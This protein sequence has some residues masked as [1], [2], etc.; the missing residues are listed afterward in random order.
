MKKLLSILACGLLIAAC[1]GG[2]GSGSTS[3]SSVIQPESPFRSAQA[4]TTPSTNA[5]MQ[6]ITIGVQWPTGQ[7]NFANTCRTPNSGGVACF[8]FPNGG[9]LRAI[10]WESS[11][12]VPHDE[13][14]FM[15]VMSP[16]SEFAGSTVLLSMHHNA[17]SGTSSNFKDVN[18]SGYLYVP[19][20][21][22]VWVYGEGTVNSHPAG[23]EIQTTLYVEGT[24]IFPVYP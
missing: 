17:A 9:K 22:F 11:I 4:Q 5:G 7:F 24:G 16:T 15:L 2:G 18:L 20:G 6:A 21:Y 3:N 1:G 14:L 19:P 10:S 23:A 13:V 8:H 12:K